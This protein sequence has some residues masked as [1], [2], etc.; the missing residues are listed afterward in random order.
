MNPFPFEEDAAK[1]I[2]ARNKNLRN[3]QPT[4]F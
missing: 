3:K 2:S 4:I 1:Q